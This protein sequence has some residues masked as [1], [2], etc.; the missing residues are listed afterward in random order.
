M[1]TVLPNTSSVPGP[2]RTVLTVHVL[3]D[4]TR[5]EVVSLLGVTG[6]RE[7]EEAKAKAV[8]VGSGVL[9]DAGFWGG[10]W[11]EVVGSGE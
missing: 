7:G 3:S 9:G 10:Q 11:W 5:P 8:G 6:T 1:F 2:F 4:S